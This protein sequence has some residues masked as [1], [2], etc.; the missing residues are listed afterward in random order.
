MKRYLAV[1][2][3]VAGAFALRLALD[4]L[5]GDRS[6]FLLFTLAVLL[7]GG[8]YGVRPGLFATIV[9]AGV[10]TW[11][12]LLP[13]GA[14]GPLTGDEWAN[15]G[16][17]V[18]TSVAMLAF[19]HQLTTWRR[20]EAASKEESA[21]L[22]RRERRL[23]DAVQDYAIYELDREGRILTWNAGAERMKGWPANEIIGRDY[24]VLHP[25]ERRS[26]GEP[27]RELRIAAEEG[28]FEEEAPRMRKDGSVFIAHV[29]L[30][31]LRNEAGEVYGFVKVTRDITERK[32]AEAEIQ[33]LNE[34]LEGLVEERTRQLQ[35]V[36]DELNA[37]T[38]TVSHD[39]RAPLRAMEG[40]GR[41]LLDEHGQVLSE[42]GR[43]YA[44]RIVG[45]AERMES[46]INDLLEYSRLTRQQL[47]LRRTEVEPI[48]SRCLDEVR[49][50][51]P[52]ARDTDFE[53][54][55]PLPAVTAEPT[56]L[57]QVLC[58]LVS[59][60][61][62]FHE[63]DGPPAQVRIWPE[64]RNGSVRLWIADNGIG[65]PPEHRERIFRVFER[66]HG[67]E[68]YPGTGVG[69][70]IVRKGMERMGG[71]CGVESEPGEGSRFWI[72]L[73]AGE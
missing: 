53:V 39:L 4:P 8:L 9:S 51:L 65:I 59:N 70:A 24:D 23:I 34:Q 38:Y 42:E 31:P 7:S 10:G 36:V 27:R 32:A 40:F 6:P 64:R 17:F 5:L 37:F 52:Q 58:N 55:A 66:L 72:E 61:V 3:L 68:Q 12:F 26:A 20:R 49:A 13:R 2:G 25:P 50:G 35:D 57:H 19:A 69:L 47:E 16:A 14:F 11:F 43:H 46:L 18:L 21:L 54:S 1:L 30:F 67:Q 41:I 56:V 62:K 45:A 29:N 22:A 63:N 15:L 60:A 73:K 28:R 44:S 33:R 48:V 71:D